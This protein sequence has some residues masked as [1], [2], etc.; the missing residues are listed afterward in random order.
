MTSRLNKKSCLGN[1]IV[2][3]WFIHVPN[4]FSA[5]YKNITFHNASFS[6]AIIDLRKDSLR[7]FWK[8]PITNQPFISIAALKKW[9]E[10]TGTSLEMATNAGIYDVGNKPLGLY[11]ENNQLLIALNERKGEGNFYLKPNG[12]FIMDDKQAAIL[13][14]SQLSSVNWS[15]RFAT[16][17]GPLLVMN[18]KIHAAFRKNSASKVIRNGIGISSANQVVIVISNTPVN[19]YDFATLFRDYFKCSNA[20]YLDGVISKM[21]VP[22]LNRVEEEGDFSALFGVITR[23]K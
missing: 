5:E 16:Q 21:Y 4:V 8:N 1:I 15:I 17:S 19:L 3:L 6:V 2:I 12:I 23:L 22:K 11:I 20:L 9:L 7:L 13:E 18:R 14:S 10:K